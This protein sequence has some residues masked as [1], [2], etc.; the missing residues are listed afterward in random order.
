[1]N[2]TTTPE[3]PKKFTFGVAKHVTRQ[4][5]KLQANTEYFFHLEGL[6]HEAPKDDDFAGSRRKKA[7]EA[8]DGK[9]KKLPPMLVDVIGLEDGETGQIIVPVVLESELKRFYP[10][11]TYVN[12]NFRFVKL[13]VA[14]KD[15]SN[16]SIQEITL[17]EGHPLI[18]V[19]PAAP[20]YDVSEQEVDALLSTAT[21]QDVGE[22]SKKKAGKAA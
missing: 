7:P 6:I 5:F 18:G 19:K 4:L 3:M 22:Q 11:H 2:A 14:G 9:P 21:V 12:R 20:V 13:P 10:N 16:W 1:M 15:Y 8:S 17:P